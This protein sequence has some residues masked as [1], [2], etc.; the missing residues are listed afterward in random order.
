LPITSDRV[1]I[2]LKAKPNSRENRIQKIDESN[3]V[4]FVKEA[5]QQGKANEAIIK[6]LAQYFKTSPL[7]I[8]IVSGRS[9]RTKII[10]IH[11]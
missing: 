7:L 8:E 10:I 9:S 5:P 11:E 3:F 2:I 4:A 1:K 6:L